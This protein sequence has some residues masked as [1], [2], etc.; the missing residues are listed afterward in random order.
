MFVWKTGL[1]INYFHTIVNFISS[2]KFNRLRLFNT[3]I[4]FYAFGIE[5]SPIVYYS[6]AR[7]K[8]DL[9][10]QYISKV[11]EIAPNE[12]TMVL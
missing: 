12:E 4:I 2:I 6:T 5:Y 8:I 3:F 10:K 9:L 11:R 1:S 7:I